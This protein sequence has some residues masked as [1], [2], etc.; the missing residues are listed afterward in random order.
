[1]VAF[2]PVTLT[3]VSFLGYLV[4]LAVLHIEVTIEQHQVVR[5]HVLASAGCHRVGAHQCVLQNAA[6]R[7][8][9]FSVAGIDQVSR[10]LE[11]QLLGFNDRRLLQVAGITG[12][13]C[14]IQRGHRERDA[15]VQAP[16]RAVINGGGLLRRVG[17]LLR[18]LACCILLA[19]AG[20]VHFKRDFPRQLSMPLPGSIS[21]F[22]RGSIRGAAL[23]CATRCCAVLGGV[24]GCGTVRSRR[25][26]RTGLIHRS[27][28]TAGRTTS[29]RPVRWGRRTT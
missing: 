11:I 5:P 7:R 26:L 27:R 14:I 1:M 28:R 18:F 16:F 25:L 29:F 6:C 4:H 12:L 20:A 13:Q 3:G 22:K 23:G 15:A 10:L 2:A 8:P 19:G 24:A 9:V 17:V 21:G